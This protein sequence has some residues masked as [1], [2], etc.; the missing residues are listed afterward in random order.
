MRLPA[1]GRD[2]PF[3]GSRPPLPRFQT[4][5]FMSFA[6]VSRYLSNGIAP[7][8][9]LRAHSR[10]L[11][12]FLAVA[13]IIGIALPA[14]A[15]PE[16]APEGKRQPVPLAEAGEYWIDTLAAFGPQQV[17][18]G[19]LN[20]SPLPARGI[21]PLHVREALWIRFTAAPQP[22]PQ[23][24]L[25]EIPYPAV[26][27]ASLYTLEGAGQWS[28]QRAGDLTPVDRWP[29]PH[30]HP[31]LLLDSSDRE[32]THYLLRIDNG[33]GFN[34]PIRFIDYPH[35]LRN[36]QK[37]SLF[38]GFYFGL[39]LLGFAVAVTA[40][41]WLRD[42]V[43]VYYGLCSV[44]VG[45]TQAAI[46]GVA[47]LY[48]W[49]HSPQWA[50]RS[51]VVLV[52]W[53]MMSVLLLN[54]TVVSLGQRSRFLS[55]LVWLVVCAGAVVSVALMV[56]DS[57]LRLKLL[58]PYV[59][60]VA[61]LVLSLNFWALRHGDRFGGW[62]LVSA[63]PL[64]FGLA[65][66][67]ARS[68][69]WIPLTFATEQ[70]VLASMAVELPALLAV[71]VLRSRHRRENTRRIKRLDR[72]DPSTGLINEQ[73][74]EERMMRMIARSVRLKQ[75]SA[76]ML[77]VLKNA[78][79][80]RRDFGRKAADELPLR[81]AERLLSTGREIDS[82]ARLSGRSFGMLL[83]GPFNEQDAAALGPR[84]VA[85]CLM[86]YNGLHPECV[87]QV[88]VAYAL[89]PLQGANAQ[90]LLSR[91]EERLAAASP[92]DRKA[93]FALGD[94]APPKRPISR[95]MPLHTPA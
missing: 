60:L 48:L 43:Y 85:R 45:M 56:T 93:V 10:A 15:A 8:R 6:S 19:S 31:L 55:K 95:R 92:D 72:I 84:I 80:T 94:A 9:W 70:G 46:T 47:S 63:V 11:T 5:C 57:A 23:R 14:L 33:R 44:L 18:S 82:T 74:F 71:L 78:E 29:L 30:R 13:L 58:L 35:L 91:L 81:V 59:G 20:W 26:D 53:T 73:V 42:R 32:P 83:E 75:Q 16:L 76:V 25:L 7:C 68:L 38:L 2:A 22:D 41:L 39:A 37:L 66:T 90:L 27:R 3:I 54:T 51:L 40:A 1:G 17:A 88:R 34:A 65:L 36:E 12:G 61:A 86:P 67:V 21:Y 28:E 50:D 4:Q 69:Q 64:A 87:A 89:V 49:P 24:W 62:L 79:H 77:I 52:C